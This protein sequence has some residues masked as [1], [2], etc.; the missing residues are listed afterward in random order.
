MKNHLIPI[1]VTFAFFQSLFLSTVLFVR[2]SPRRVNL[3]LA[4]LLLSSGMAITYEIIYPLE[5]YRLFPHL[6][7]IYVPTQFLLGPCL[8]F[9]VSA[10]TEPDFRFSRSKWI[11]LLPFT[12][13]LLYLLPFA[14]K[15]AEE[16]TAFAL[17]YIAPSRPTSIEEWTI[18]LSLQVSVWIYSIYCLKKI[19]LYRKRIKEILSDINKVTLNWLFLFVSTI[20]IMQIPNIVIDIKMLMGASLVSFNSSISLFLSII[21]VLLG[22][23]GIFQLEF[24]IEPFEKYD[25]DVSL[26]GKEL[27]LLFIE[28]KKEVTEKKLYLKPDLTLP[29]LAENLAI[30][31]NELSRTINQGGNLNFY[32]FINALRVQEIKE[33]LLSEEQAGR[34]ILDLA[35]DAGFNSKSAFHNAFKRDTGMS[36]LQFRSRRLETLVR[37]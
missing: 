4:L 25:K 11:H 12:A 18:W 6:C 28:V 21:I 31:R 32:E 16:K 8:Y 3:Y 36:P 10:I 14:L 15:S 23:R 24:I 34:N 37:G 2:K 29:E 22:W 30:S 33:K 1:I 17:W 13:S 27:H 5:L 19:L 7:K 26:P 9:Y 20:L 35:F